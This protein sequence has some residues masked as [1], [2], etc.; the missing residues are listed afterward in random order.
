[1][2]C[3]NDGTCQRL[4]KKP[5]KCLCKKQW[6]GPRCQFDV[7]EC[8]M[9]RTNICLNNGTCSNYPGGYKCHCGPNYLGEHCEQK[10]IC[11]EKAPCFNHGQCRPEG[12]HY[13]CECLSSFTGR[14]KTF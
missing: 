11:L 6:Y 1:M 13:Y 7:D 10:H 3:Q 9:N 12:E 4:P 2:N 14:R 8:S 5:A